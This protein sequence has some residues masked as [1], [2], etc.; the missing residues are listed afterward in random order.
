[1]ILT[2]LIA[3]LRARGVILEARGDRLIVDAPAGLLTNDL[4]DELRRSKLAILAH[5]RTEHGAPQSG[6]LA[7]IRIAPAAKPAKD[8]WTEPTARECEVIVMLRNL[9][10]AEALRKR[11]ASI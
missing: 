8:R 3:E 10:E 5:L 2:D 4:R 11:T 6:G 7:E 9:A 1:M